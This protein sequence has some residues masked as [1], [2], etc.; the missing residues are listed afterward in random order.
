MTQPPPRMQDTLYH[1]VLLPDE[2]K[3]VR[4]EARDFARLHIEPQAY[5]I[6][7]SEEAVERFPRDLF[8]MM[9]LQGLF[10]LAFPR[11]DGGRGLNYPMCAATVAMEELAYASNA[12][13]AIYDVHCILAGHALLYGSES[14]RQRYL[15]P[16]L[17]GDR[18]ACFAVTEPEAGSDLSPDTVRTV[19][20]RGNARWVVSGRKRF[21]INAP[22]GDFAAALCATDRGLSMLVIDLDRDGVHVG[23]VD[24][25]MGIKGCLTADLLFD[26]VEVPSENLIGSEGKGLNVALGALTCGRIAVGASGVGMAQAAFD[27]ATAYIKQRQSF[28][29]PIAQFQYWQFKFAEMATQL[30]NARNLCYKAAFRRDSGVEFPE[31]EVAMAKQFGTELATEMAATAVQAFGGYGYMNRLGAN[32]SHYKVEQIYRDCA[33][34]R[35]YEGT[36]EIQKWLIARRI[37]GR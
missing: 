9:G 11:E 18:I 37:F 22:V 19:A 10:G 14:V 36:N 12:I 26:N 34:A 23:E 31:P 24:R 8:R 29:V 13:A 17:A 20:K 30:E 1:D 35:I 25:K 3:R 27:E 28:G 16:L 6:G 4:Q 32:G 2:T 33:T 21:I 5:E 7:S 15:G